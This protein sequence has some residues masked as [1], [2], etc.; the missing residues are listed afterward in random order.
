M[1]KAPPPP[2]PTTPLYISM[3]I[4]AIIMCIDKVSQS[5]VSLYAFFLLFSLAEYTTAIAAVD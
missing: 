5:T 4:I 2:S 1:H 3:T